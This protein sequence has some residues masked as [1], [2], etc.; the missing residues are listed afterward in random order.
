MST[1]KSH[2]RTH[3]DNEARNKIEE[4]GGAFTEQFLTTDFERRLALHRYTAR[5]YRYQPPVVVCLHVSGHSDWVGGDTCVKSESDR[6]KDE[7]VPNNPNRQRRNR[8]CKE[9]SRVGT[10]SQD[11]AC[12]LEQ[13]SD[14]GDEADTR[15]G[16]AGLWLCTDANEPQDTSVTAAPM[17]D[18]RL[19][20]PTNPSQ[21]DCARIA[22]VVCSVHVFCTTSL[23]SKGWCS[24]SE[25]VWAKLRCSTPQRRTSVN[26]STPFQRGG[27][28]SRWDFLLACSARKKRRNFLKDDVVEGVCD[29]ELTVHC[30]DLTK[31][32]DIPKANVAKLHDLPFC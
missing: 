4:E 24:T 6:R 3:S 30:S 20:T 8:S 2:A 28:R 10:R 12:R 5:K 26:A 23:S 14:V 21:C 18:R 25:T 11:G 16:H 19:R 29:Q 1:T 32:K 9:E 31:F 13:C 17:R 15:Y 27:C 7:S 22:C